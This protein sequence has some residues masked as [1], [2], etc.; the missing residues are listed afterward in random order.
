[1]AVNGLQQSQQMG[2]EALP[3]IITFISVINSVLHIFES[4]LS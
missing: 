4:I 2:P 3:Q 1:M